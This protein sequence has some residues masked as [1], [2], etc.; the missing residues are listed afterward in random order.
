MQNKNLYFISRN[1]LR[2]NCGGSIARTDIEMVM[3]RL[4]CKNIGLKRTFHHNSITHAIRNSLG[5]M[6]ALSQLKKGD[7]LILQYPMKLYFKLLCDTARKRGA[8]VINIV[9]DLDSFSPKITVEQEIDL[10]NRCDIL[11]PHNHMMRK[12]LQDQGCKVKMIDYE[13]MDYLHGTS[14]APHQPSSRKYSIFFVGNASCTLNN[15]LYQLAEVM[16]DTD[17]YLYG[18]NPATQFT[19][20]L[21]NLHPMGFVKDTEIIARH[22]G[23][24]GIS[25]Y[26]SSLDDGVGKGIY[27]NYNNP[28]KVSL[29]LRCNA[30]V[31]VWNKAGRAEFIEKEGIGISVDS[32]R[33]LNA[34]FARISTEDYEKMTENVMRVNQRLAAGYYLENA[35]AQALAYLE[36]NNP[37]E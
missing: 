33:E 29:Y 30:P 2:L 37:P 23:D 31:I 36:K 9:H 10:L 28:H 4:G 22:Q 6:R 7:V 25:W 17:I 21:P 16:P 24:F 15:H 11:L 3:E 26:G 5:A 18:T 34:R 14:D 27:M 19:E 1:Y 12:W 13:I 35:L 20:R 32:L 8:K